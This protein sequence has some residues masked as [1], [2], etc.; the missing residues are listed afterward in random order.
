MVS[1]QFS[2]WILQ[3]I[4]K[5]DALFETHL[6]VLIGLKIVYLKSFFFLFF[7]I[8]CHGIKN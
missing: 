2:L 6:E 1:S 5:G 4:I 7:L 8:P 3:S